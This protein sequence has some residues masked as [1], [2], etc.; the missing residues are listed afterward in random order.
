MNTLDHTFYYKCVLQTASHCC[1]LDYLAKSTI[2][3][4]IPVAFITTALCPGGAD[5]VGNLLLAFNRMEAELDS[6]L[7]EC[8]PGLPGQRGLGR[9]L[10]TAP[11]M[12]DPC[13]P[14]S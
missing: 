2:G 12:L 5:Q 9:F 1:P 11:C 7:W 6:G 3:R 8:G 4:W 14:W 13:L 10:S